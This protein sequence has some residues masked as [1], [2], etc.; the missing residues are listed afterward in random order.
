MRNVVMVTWCILK[1]RF[2]SFHRHSTGLTKL[3][4][5]VDALGLLQ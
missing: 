4:Q 3:Y 2:T 1:V 5:H